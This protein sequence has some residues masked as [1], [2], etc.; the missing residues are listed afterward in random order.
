[1][2]LYDPFHS[3]VRPVLC[4]YCEFSDHDG[5]NCSYRAYVDAECIS[6]EKMIKDMTDKKVE[7]MKERVAEYSRCFTQTREDTNLQDPDSSLGYPKP[8]VSLCDDFEPS[9]QS[10][11]NLHDVMPLPSLE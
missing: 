11:Y 5:C 9:Y 3:Y 2:R 7:T 8:K 4:D 10:R 1:M 6:V